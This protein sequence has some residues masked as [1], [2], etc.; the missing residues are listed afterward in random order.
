MN[1]FRK[2]QKVV[3]ILHV[4]GIK[5]ASLTEVASVRKGIVRLVDSE[6]A[7]YEDNNGR[8]IDPLVGNAYT[9]IIALET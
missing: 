2:G 8:E 7:Q 1:N 6:Q 4:A 3:R 9:E 5:S